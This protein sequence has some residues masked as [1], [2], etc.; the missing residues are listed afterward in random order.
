MGLKYLNLGSI[1][2][3][4]ILLI[5][6]AIIPCLVIFLLS[7]IEQR[8]HLVDKSKSDVILLTQS[9]AESQKRMAQSTR[10]ILSVLSLL[11]SIQEMKP[12]E[13]THILTSILAQNPN[14]NNIALLNLKGD[15]LASGK[16][17][18]NTN[19][20]DRRHVKAA[21]ATKKFATG[22]YIVTRVGTH[23]PSFPFAF[24]V[25]DTQGELKAVLT[26]AVKVDV[27]SQLFEASSLPE[28]SFV[29][30][31]DSQGIRLFYY[32]AQDNTN[33][34]GKPIGANSWDIARKGGDDGFFLGKGSDG[35]TRIF[36]YKKVGFGDDAKPYLYVWAGIPEDY[37]L[38][39]ANASLIRNLF[40]ML[41]ATIVSLVTA[42]LI[43]QKMIVTPIKNL[44]VLAE[45]ISRGDLDTQGKGAGAAGEIGTLTLAF[46][47]MADALKKSLSTLQ[48]YEHIVSSSTDKMA[49]VDR[50]FTYLSVNKAYL[51]TF[52]LTSEQVI[53]KKISQVL[54]EKLFDSI[55]YPYGK[56]CLEGE[57]IQFQSWFDL[58]NSKKKYMDIKYS[59]YRDKN[60]AIIGFVVNG[61]DITKHK[62][63]EDALL[64]EK[65]KLQDALS[66]IKQL[67]GLIPI[68][69]HC[70]KIRDDQGY[71]NQIEAYISQHSEA[72]FSHG[73]CKDC[74]EKHY[75]EYVNP[76]ES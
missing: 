45:K 76:K 30:V 31:T 50:Q 72:V 13:C 24:P 16:P 74:L 75:S 28:K 61:R 23:N 53:G 8:N 9:M 71:W 66:Q 56:R 7:H 62:Q 37:I 54:D 11:P 46:Y 29:S 12:E 73:I 15:V 59:P 21:L 51:E 14:Y 48:E 19:L 63:A 27:F 4:L 6:V 32:P 70:K 26:A 41:V 3:K 22:E 43:G 35:L 52:E 34:I 42:W 5:G 65:N 10:E 1:R 40:F 60:N 58:S 33:P 20:A 69:S 64:A 68:C 39:P 25:L 44:E 67:S 55:I 47:R 49:L 57:N 2:I 18:S 36:A 38:A 17:F